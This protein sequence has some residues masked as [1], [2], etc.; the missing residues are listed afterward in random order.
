MAKQC[1]GPFKISG[2][3]N[4]A[5]CTDLTNNMMA[6]PVAAA[7]DANNWQFYKSG[8]FTSCD[9]NSLNHSVLVVTMTDTYWRLKNTWGTSWGES[10]Y[11]RIGP[12]NTCG[13]CRF[14]SRP[15]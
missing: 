2:Y 1:T 12:G 13:V 10:G 15:K 6:G 3:N 8:I 14:G 5:S 11:I 9:P 7:V 4:V